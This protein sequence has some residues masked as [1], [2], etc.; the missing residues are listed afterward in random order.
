[1]AQST[2]S[3]VEIQG[4]QTRVPRCLGLA[5]C[6]QRQRG[7]PI[8][9][10]SLYCEPCDS[11]C[12]RWFSD[13]MARVDRREVLADGEVQGVRVRNGWLSCVLLVRSRGLTLTTRLAAIPDPQSSF[14]L[15]VPRPKGPSIPIARAGAKRWPG[16][17]L[18]AHFMSGCFAESAVLEATG[19][20][21]TH[22][23]SQT[24]RSKPRNDPGDSSDT[25]SQQTPAH[26][27]RR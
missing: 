26:S 11:A 14:L 19:T 25:P 27:R 2:Y 13:H 24:Q 8:A 7:H 22:R 15:P 16:F 23:G 1:M 20:G 6:H 3:T 17:A 21:R 5:G 18:S 4:G 10:D 9:I 12:Q